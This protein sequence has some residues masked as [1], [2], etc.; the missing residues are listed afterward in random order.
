MFMWMY[1]Y[2]VLLFT[3]FPRSFGKDVLGGIAPRILYQLDVDRLAGYMRRKGAIGDPQ[4]RRLIEPNCTSEQRAQQLQLVLSSAIWDEDPSQFVRDF[5]LALCD[6][7]EDDGQRSHYQ[8]AQ[9][10]R[11]NGRER[12][13]VCV[14]AYN[15]GRP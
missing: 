10:L 6:L 3:G 15:V 8:L 5:Y 4:Y 2:C 12:V 7:Y 9:F 1:W 13:C 11:G 14:R